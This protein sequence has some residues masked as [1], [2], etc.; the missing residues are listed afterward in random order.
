MNRT[1]EWVADRRCPPRKK[2]QGLA[3]PGRRGFILPPWLG[4]PLSGC[5]PAGPNSVS[6]SAATIARTAGAARGEIQNSPKCAH[7]LT[8]MN[9]PAESSRKDLPTS[10][11][12]EI[13]VIV[14]TAHWLVLMRPSVADFNAPRDSDD[15]GD[16]RRCE[17]D[18]HV[19]QHR[20]HVRAAFASGCQHDHRAWLKQL[21]DFR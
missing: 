12:E 14:T 10:R 5:S 9:A 6:P 11:R 3:A 13:T 18:H 21:I 1:K 19:P 20:H 7:R 8:P 16:E 15:A 4:Y 17:F 2:A